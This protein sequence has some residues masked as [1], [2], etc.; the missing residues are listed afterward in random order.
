MRATKIFQQYVEKQSHSREFTF[1][2][3]YKTCGVVD[4]RSSDVV[5]PLLLNFTQQQSG[6]CLR[7]CCIDDMQQSRAV[8]EER[9]RS[10]ADRRLHMFFISVLFCFCFLAN[11]FTFSDAAVIR[12]ACQ[13]SNNLTYSPAKNRT[14]AQIRKFNFEIS[15]TLVSMLWCLKSIHISLTLIWTLLWGPGGPKV[16]K[17]KKTR[18][19]LLKQFQVEKSRDFMPVQ[20]QIF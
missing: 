10:I 1:Y 16:P 18:N 4:L 6:C 14:F 5:P 17:M 2:F 7:F 13:N 19:T 12:E 11:I 8:A 15:S 3:Y 9:H 20:I